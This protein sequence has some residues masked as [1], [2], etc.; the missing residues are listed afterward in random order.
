MNKFFI[1]LV[2]SLGLSGCTFI[3]SYHRPSLPVPEKFSYTGAQTSEGHPSA[4]DIGWQDFFK[5]PRLQKLIE[6]AL[7]N[8]RDYRLAL[9]NVEQIRDQYRIV[10]YALLP[11]FGIQGSGLRQ[12]SLTASKYSDTRSYQLN[13]N[14][15]YELDLFGQIRSLKAQVLEQYLASQEASRAAMI[16]LV[17]E[18]AV[19]YFTQRAL[20]E[21]LE[22][23][24]KTLEAVKAYDDLIEKSYRLGN[25]SALE[26]QLAQVQVQSVKVAIAND[27]RQ[28]SQA[29]DALV[30][31]IGQPLPDNLPLPQALEQQDLIEDLPVGLS[32]DLI[33]QRP[34]ILQAEHQLKAANANI[35]AVRASFFPTITLTGLDGTASVKLAKLFTPG[36]QVWNFSPQ[37]SLP[38]FNQSTNFA[39]LDAAQVARRIEITRYEKVI[40][41]AFREVSDAIIARDDLNEQVKAQ[42][43]LLRAQQDRY[44]LSDARYQGGIDSYLPVLLAQQDLYSTKANLIQVSADRLVNLIAL[45]KALGGGWKK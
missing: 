2:L 25:A 1:P 8:N 21:H 34:D 29:L 26:V 42:R 3:P 18:V 24:I 15:S 37:V 45:Y 9:L 43:D 41:T 28:C 10:H 40:Q 32:S 13:V 27:Q 11:S 17:A 14:T 36:S 4:Y 35:G 7:N 38:L 31:L 44:H 30:L 20:E 6:L 23:L 16:S 5:D 12:R 33:E 19:Q 22:L 39:N